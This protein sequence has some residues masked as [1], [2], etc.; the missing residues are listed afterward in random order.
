MLLAFARLLLLTP[1]HLD[2]CPFSLSQDLENIIVDGL[3]RTNGLRD[4]K[5][6][7]GYL[8]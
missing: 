2:P 8:V 6:R 7:E 5:T 3:G 4:I 1:T